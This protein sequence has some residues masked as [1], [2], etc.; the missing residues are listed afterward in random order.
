MIAGPVTAMIDL[1]SALTWNPGVRGVLVVAVGVIVLCG[2]VFL[3]LSTNSGTRLG[4]LLALT[5]LMGWMTIMGL[6]WSIYGIGKQGATATWVV[7][8]LNHDDLTQ[9]GVT[10]ARGLP[11]PDELPSA[12]SIL[13]DDPALAKQF[14]SGEGI[15]PPTLGDLIG[16]KPEL[17]DRINRDL[18][19]GWELLSTADPQTGEAQASASAFLTEE[20]KL[21]EKQ[22]DFVVLEAFSLGGKAKKPEDAGLL[23]SAWFKVKR[24]VSWPFGHPAHYAVVQVQRVIPVEP[25]PGQPPAIPRPDPDAEVLSVIMERDLGTKRLPS[26]GVTIF[27]GLVFAICCN[28]LHRRDRLVARARSAALART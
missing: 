20:R 15:K 13:A 4:F 8:E 9:A 17:A 6:V 26:V 28:S 5:G 2:S 3:I 27:S 10:Q 1:F 21:F 7:K 16:V 18:P 12:E 11:E 25:E 24:I 23:E 14:P 22:T 19:E